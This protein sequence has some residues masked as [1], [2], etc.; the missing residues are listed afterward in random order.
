MAVKVKLGG[1]RRYQAGGPV[2]R[3]VGHRPFWQRVLLFCAVVGLGGLLLGGLIFG[4]LYNYYQHV[5]DDRLNNGPLFASTAQVY[6]APREV[7][8]GQTLTA[9]FIAQDLRR[10]GYNGNPQL[11]TYQLS[12]DTITIKPGPGSF[13]STDGA[14]IDTAGGSVQSITADNGAALRAYELEP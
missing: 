4:Y 3:M 12:D 6:A 10:A 5:V 2:R 8:T 13:H 9:A 11:G 14:T 7:R 1:D